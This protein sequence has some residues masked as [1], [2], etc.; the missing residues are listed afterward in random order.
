MIVSCGPTT[1]ML[2]T[3][4]LRPLAAV[5]TGPAV[6]SGRIAMRRTAAASELLTQTA[7]LWTAT[8]L[9][10]T[11]PCGSTARSSADWPAAAVKWATMWGFR[12]R[13]GGGVPKA[14]D[15]ADATD[16]ADAVRKT[17]ITHTDARAAVRVAKRMGLLGPGGQVEACE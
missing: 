11:K 5:L 12:A 13:G 8:P 7:P 15:A 17:A 10:P 14:G 9:A 3:R 4:P 1:V 6:P 2:S 16:A